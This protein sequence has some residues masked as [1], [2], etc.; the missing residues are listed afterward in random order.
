M[1]LGLLRGL[2][3]SAI[4]PPWQAPDEIAHFEYTRLLYEKRR[5]L[6]QRDES[7]SLQRRVVSSLYEHKFWR[8][9]GLQS[10][11]PIP[12]SLRELPFV[13]K[14]SFLNRPSLAYLL[15]ALSLAPV[16]RQDIAVQLYSVRM[17]S[18]A[19]SI[20]TVW[21]GFLATKEAYPNDSFLLVAVPAF[22]AFLPMRTYLVS[23]V[24]EEA[25]A[26]FFAS[27]TIYLLIKV[28]TRGPSLV[29]VI[30][31]GL[32]LTL[33]LWTKATAAFLAPLTLMAVLIYLIGNGWRWSSAAVKRS[34]LLFG[35]MLI[36]PVFAVRVS[37]AYA[38]FLQFISRAPSLVSPTNYSA[39][40]IL[41][42]WNAFLSAYRSFWGIFGWMALPLDDVWYDLAS[43]LT[44]ASLIGLTFFVLQIM[45]SPVQEKLE[46]GMVF[47]LIVSA[48]FLSVGSLMALIVVL[49]QGR[50]LGQG[51][52]VFP[53]ILPFSILLT[54]GLKQLIPSRFHDVSLV[55]FIGGLISMDWLCLM[56]YIIPFFYGS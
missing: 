11:D 4:I 24:N 52:Y 7:L 27:L 37:P 8:H 21:L 50:F 38:I 9:V 33:A 41:G 5:L 26:E 20:L 34:S 40:A 51:R 15:G 25:L 6:T 56:Y 23:A 46:R 47:S 18:V 19:L 54:L 2:L 3:Y 29:R 12:L 45:K 36:F 53:A 22:I 44:L 31:L 48:A 14:I 13:G 10:P 28:L 32:T 55:A 42:Y 43:L 35:M 16:L 39:E 17:A 30:S 1:A 49:P